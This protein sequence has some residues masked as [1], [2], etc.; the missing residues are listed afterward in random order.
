VE[1]PGSVSHGG[2]GD[3]PSGDTPFRPGTTPH[4]AGHLSFYR[5]RWFGSTSLPP[6]HA[7]AQ[8]PSPR[9]AGERGNTPGPNR[10]NIILCNYLGWFVAPRPAER[11]EGCSAPARGV[12]RRRL[13]PGKPG[14]RPGAGPGEGLCLRP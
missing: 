12:D 7:G 3:G 8:H 4:P 5:V 9:R 13:L 6:A 11:G 1:P 14:R 2:A 10:A